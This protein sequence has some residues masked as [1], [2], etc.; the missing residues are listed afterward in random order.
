MRFS[1]WTAG[2]AAILLL[3]ANLFAGD[4]QRVILELTSDGSG[5]TPETLAAMQ[6]GALAGAWF[7]WKGAVFVLVAG[8]IQG[9]VGSLVWRLVAGRIEMPEAVREEVAELLQYDP[10]SA[11]GLMTAQFV[12]VNTGGSA[13]GLNVAKLREARRILLANEVTNLDRS[14]IA[15]MDITVE[16]NA[17]DRG[18]RA[19]ADIGGQR[20]A[21]TGDAAVDRRIREFRDQVLA[22]AE[23]QYDSAT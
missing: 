2:I 23:V 17:F 5:G 10:E 3:G 16:R 9:T 4:E 19:F 13:S 20:E 14:P 11:G 15:A 18:D 7:G 1:L 6:S 22:E 12:S 8:A 21:R